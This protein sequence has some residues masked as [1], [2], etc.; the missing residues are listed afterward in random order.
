MEAGKVPASIVLITTHT[1]YYRIHETLAMKL[2]KLQHQSQQVAETANN[3]NRLET[4]HRKLMGK[5]P[6]LLFEHGDSI[7]NLHPRNS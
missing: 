3:K 4:D 7:G 6:P 2:L 5:D 1:P